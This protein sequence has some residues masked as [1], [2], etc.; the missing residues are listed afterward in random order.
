METRRFKKL[1]ELTPE[2]AK[3]MR[4]RYLE[5]Y[6]KVKTFWATIENGHVIETKEVST[7]G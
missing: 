1:P 2:E 6:P 4:D 3:K 5:L 7:D